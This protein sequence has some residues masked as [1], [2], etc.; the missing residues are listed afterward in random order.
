MMD[1]KYDILKHPNLKFTADGSREL[2]LHGSTEHAIDW[3]TITL[4]EESSYEL[5]SEEDLE[6]IIQSKNTN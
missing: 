3:K 5:F 6:T 4:N 1:E 2:Y